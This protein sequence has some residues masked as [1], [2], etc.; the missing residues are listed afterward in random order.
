MSSWSLPT[1]N[2]IFL[3]NE[4]GNSFIVADTMKPCS[5]SMAA[6]A[7]FVLYGCDG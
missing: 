7:C 5:W 4:T 1:G 3:K 2:V 6:K